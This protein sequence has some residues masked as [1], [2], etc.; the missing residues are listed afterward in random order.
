MSVAVSTTMSRVWRA[1]DRGALRLMK[2]GSTFI[3]EVT[4]ADSLVGRSGRK[5][6][7]SIYIPAAQG[8]L[9]YS[10]VRFLR[11]RRTLEVGMANGI[12][13]LYIAQALQDLGSGTHLAIDPYQLSQ[14]DD[15]GMV[16]LERA[17][18]NHLVSID[19]RPSHWALPDLDEAGQR[20]QFAF[21]DGSHLFDYVMTD[22]MAIDRI[23]DV[24]GLIAFDD[25][26]WS[27]VNQVIRFALANRAYEVFPTGV[28]IEPGPGRPRLAANGLR[29]IVRRW[30]ALRAIVRDDF[31]FPDRQLDI[32]G[33]C[34]VLRKAADD[35]RDSLRGKLVSF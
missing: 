31:T 4:V 19:R 22:F 27:A 24:G 8:N 25:S 3:D 29:W 23:L 1:P 32:D 35:R 15:V 7:L 10:L 26:D 6:P 20:I 13:S 9:L 12:S 17:E 28:V 5:Q 34:V 21:V 14:W 18:L 11:P 33:R 30:K 2:A 16:T